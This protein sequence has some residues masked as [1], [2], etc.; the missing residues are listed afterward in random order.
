MFSYLSYYLSINF[1]FCANMMKNVSIGILNEQL[2]K[3][4]KSK[5]I[6]LQMES[7]SKAG[8]KEPKIT[9]VIGAQALQMIRPKMLELLWPR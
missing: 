6:K 4:V 7:S 9:S 2:K 1:F 5:M 8:A 3:S